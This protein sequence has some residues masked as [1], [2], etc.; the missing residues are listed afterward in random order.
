[1][2][3]LTAGKLIRRRA[4]DLGGETRTMRLPASTWKRVERAARK[5]HLDVD[6]AMRL[7]VLDWLR[8]AG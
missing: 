8:R 2:P 4:G 6:R 7:A 3:E 5:Q 1:M